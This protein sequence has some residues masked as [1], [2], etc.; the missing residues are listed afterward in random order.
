MFIFTG[1]VSKPK[2]QG[3]EMRYQKQSMCDHGKHKCGS[4]LH[5]HFLTKI[6]QCSSY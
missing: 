1:S 4:K 2:S 5:E 6:K 3:T